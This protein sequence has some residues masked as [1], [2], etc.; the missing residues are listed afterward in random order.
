MA[1]KLGNIIDAIE[2]IVPSEFAEEWD[3]CGMQLGDRDWRI[4]KI[5]VALDPLPEVISAACQEDIDLVI[6]H[7]PLIFKSLTSIDVSTMEGVVIQ[8]AL[9]HQVAIFSAHTNLDRAKDGVNDILAS[10]IGL[11]ITNTL[12]NDL[13][14]GIPGFGRIGELVQPTSLSALAKNIKQTLGI[15]HVKVAG[16]LDMRV[17][18][19]A[20][21]SGSGSSMVSAFLDSGADVFISGD[22]R[23]HDARNFEFAQKALIDIGHFASEHLIVE[24]F[25]QQ[26]DRHF[27]SK[28]LT[29]VVEPYSLEKDPFVMI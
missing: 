17:K 21:C 24:T 9:D 8:Q 5:W 19:V 29:L 28:G 4:N 20:V 23:Y 27:Q 26:L 2:E 14:S 6:T 12:S 13:I 7:H 1:C 15:D 18:T 16:N 11:S 25:A 10:R 3:N 22:L